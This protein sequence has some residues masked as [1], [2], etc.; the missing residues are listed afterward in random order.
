[1]T[2]EVFELKGY[3]IDDKQDYFTMITLSA[4][5]YSVARYQVDPT[6]TK[7]VLELQQVVLGSEAVG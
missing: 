6:A 7:K 2:E 1:M 3:T 4:G 5:T